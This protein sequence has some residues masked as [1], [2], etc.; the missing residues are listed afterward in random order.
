MNVLALVWG[1][2]GCFR[3]GC[4]QGLPGDGGLSSLSVALPLVGK[5][6]LPGPGKGPRRPLPLESS[7]APQKGLIQNMAALVPRVGSYPGA[8]H[9]GSVEKGE[10]DS[11]VGGG[12]TCHSW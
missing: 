3:Q 4:V 6:W 5:M 1:D 2:L 12:G 7:W 11:G 9:G 10:L 8:G